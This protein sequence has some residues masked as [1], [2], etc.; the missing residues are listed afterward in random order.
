MANIIFIIGDTGTGKSTS[1]RNLDNE[2]TLI[3]NVL[4]KEL[5]WKGSRKQYSKDKKNIRQVSKRDAIIETLKLKKDSADIF[6]LDDIGYSMTE[7]FFSTINVTG[8]EKF[9]RIG[10]N[11]QK[12]IKFA[13]DEISSEK[14][15][16]FMFHLEVDEKAA[17]L[18][19]KT[20][21]KLLDDKYNPL[22]VT[23]MALFTKVEIGKEGNKYYFIT[24]RSI[25]D[26]NN[27]VP[28]KCPEGMFP[29]SKIP[30]DLDY[31]LK[32]MHAYY[33]DEEM[34]PLPEGYATKEEDTTVT[35]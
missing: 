33:N 8:Y 17:L 13:K 5:P 1:M 20:I 34:P 7:E 35:N 30:N 3:I 16:I 6:I 26:D 32:C 18:K 21:G 22:G 19:I 14:T 10:D 29:S 28:A 12:I 2:K 15:V 31:V 23:P 11:M 9:S 27:I 25:D 4:G 24:Q